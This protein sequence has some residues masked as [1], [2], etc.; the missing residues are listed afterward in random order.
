MVE[1]SHPLSMFMNSLP[2]TRS[3]N[4]PADRIDELKLPQMVE[5]NTESHG[6]AFTVSVDYAVGTSTGISASDR[7]ATIAALAD[8]SK[9]PELFHRPGHIFPLRAKPTGVLERP[10]HTEASVDLPRLAGLFPAGAMC[11]IVK[12]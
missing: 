4:S 10:G 11:E 6:T 12:K 5:K 8:T 1:C 9:G 7:A 3:I 2:S